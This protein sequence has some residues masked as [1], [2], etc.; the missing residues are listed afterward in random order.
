MSS[1]ESY[2]GNDFNADPNNPIAVPISAQI[3]SIQINLVDVYGGEFSRNNSIIT[4]QVE[5]AARQ[6]FSFNRYSGMVPSRYSTVWSN[7]YENV[8][9]EI[10][11]AQ[12]KA[13]NE[14]FAHYS[15]MLNVMEAFTLMA[16][17]DVW[18]DMPYSEAFQGID[19]LHPKF[20]TQA[21]IYEVIFNLLDKA[22]ILLSGNN[23]A[24]P[25]EMMIYFTMVILI[26]GLKLP[27]RL[28][29]EGC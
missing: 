6:C 18:D 29:Q 1:C 11:L 9:N 24:L 27:M 4:Q 19:N 13:E 15:G 14:G 7:I 23:E 12:K 3:P 25:S 2:I 20:D 26:Y 5:G 16:A 17:T 10:K 22:V 21:S 28:K 8:L